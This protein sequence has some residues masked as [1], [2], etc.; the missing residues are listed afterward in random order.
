MRYIIRYAKIFW[1]YFWAVL[2][3]L[4]LFM[5]VILASLLST[6]GNLAF[7]LSKIWAR[8][9]L[10]ATGVR[11]VIQGKDK[12]AKGRSYVIIS[13]HQSLYDI[14]AIVTSLGIQYRWVIKKELLN[15]PLFGPALYTSR[16]IFIDRSNTDRARESIRRGLDRL[17]GGVSVMFFAEGTRSPDGQLREFKK[18]AFAAA[19]ERS[20][21]ILPV[22]VTGSRKVLPKGSIVFTPGRIE[23]IISDPIDT[24]G[25]NHDNMQELME[26][27]RTVIGSRLK[28]D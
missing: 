20:F 9:M 27:T 28:P 21:P 11:V 19:L 14:I 8:V 25:Y 15:I 23:V 5:P 2:M 26:K 22:T 17:P 16:N 4:I 13:N 3:T 7:T 18:G 24:R 1:I 12:I 10:L 6:T